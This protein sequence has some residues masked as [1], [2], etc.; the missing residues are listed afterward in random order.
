MKYLVFLTLVLT[1]L[2]IA[3][4]VQSSQPSHQTQVIAL[5]TANLGTPMPVP[6]PCDCD[7]WIGCFPC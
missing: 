6:I 1:S 3:K 7:P 5:S 4:T 2:T